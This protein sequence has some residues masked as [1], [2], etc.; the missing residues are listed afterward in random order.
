MR[1]RWKDG[2]AA[3]AGPSFAAPDVC[4]RLSVEGLAACLSVVFAR[5][6]SAQT[7]ARRW[8]GHRLV[9]LRMGVQIKIC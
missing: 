9:S 2:S 7:P 4:W 5:V 3:G 1:P 6:S 8:Y